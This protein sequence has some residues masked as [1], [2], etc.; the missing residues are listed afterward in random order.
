MK[1][2]PAAT[3]R[4]PAPNGRDNP[5]LHDPW[6]PWYY[7]RHERNPAGGTGASTANSP[8]AAQRGTAGNVWNILKDHSIDPA[9]EHQ[10]TTRATFL[11]SQAILAAD[12]F[13]TETLTGAT[14]HVLAVIEHATRRVR[15]PG[16][17]AHPTAA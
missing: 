13:E 12:F 10:R 9:P 11:R 14:P 8:P 15:I 1:H 2:C 4:P 17:T 5:V 6:A 3:R 7:G 16:A